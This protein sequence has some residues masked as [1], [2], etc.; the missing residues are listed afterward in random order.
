M[1]MLD[2]SFD[3][4]LLSQAID[5]AAP[6]L[7][8][9]SKRHPEW[10]RRRMREE[11]DAVVAGQRPIGSLAAIAI[12]FAA[13]AGLPTGRASISKITTGLIIPF[14]GRQQ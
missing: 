2:L 8:K 13:E 14:P 10:V 6:L 11:V 4:E 9:Q 3:A 7:A 1:Q 5:Y 12:G